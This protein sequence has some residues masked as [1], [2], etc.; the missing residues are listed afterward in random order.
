MSTF[1]VICLEDQDD[2][3]NQRWHLSQ[4]IFHS[5]VEATDY[6]LTIAISRTPQVLEVLFELPSDVN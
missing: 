2:L 4:K 6:A 5:V 1:R 3:G